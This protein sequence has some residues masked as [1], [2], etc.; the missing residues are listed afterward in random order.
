MELRVRLGMFCVQ[1]STFWLV[2]RGCFT[3]VD[4]DYLGFSSTLTVRTFNDREYTRVKLETPILRRLT[5]FR[6]IS[7][8]MT[9]LP[10]TQTSTQICDFLNLSVHAMS[11]KLNLLYVSVDSVLHFA[12]GKSPIS[13]QHFSLLILTYCT[14]SC[15]PTRRRHATHPRASCCL[16]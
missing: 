16:S 1:I 10:R 6:A 14:F 3:D 12:S 8:G 11:P 7:T 5:S 9:N 2:Y 13:F 15:N 4:P